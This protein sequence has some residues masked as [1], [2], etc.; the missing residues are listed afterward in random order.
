MAKAITFPRA[1]QHAIDRLQER[2]QAQR[3]E[4]KAR[5]LPAEPICVE[6]L[7]LLQRNLCGCGCGE[8]LDFDAKWS[9]KDCPPGFPIIAHRLARGSRG[10]HVVGN[11]FIDRD[12]CNKR[13][14]S[15]D[16]TGAA[17]VKRFTPN[18][19]AKL[20]PKSEDR[21]TR[22][23]DKASGFWKPKGPSVLSKAHRNYVKRGF[24]KR[25]AK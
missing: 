18:M 14:A 9:A 4:T 2:E 17:S 3:S 12:A 13:D 25:A 22:S 15:A 16:T 7:L 8:P 1:P 24:G 5:N 21:E 6:G 10:G 23:P 11:V 19:Q 20:L